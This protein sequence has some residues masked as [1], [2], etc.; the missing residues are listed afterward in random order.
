MKMYEDERG[1]LITI[2]ELWDEF[3]QL[4]AIDPVEYAYDFDE[5]VSN[6]TGKNGTLKEVE[7]QRFSYET[8]WTSV[9]R[10]LEQFLNAFGIRFEM[11]EISHM[12]RRFDMIGTEKQ[13]QQVVKF[14][15]EVAV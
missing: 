5:Y 7:V 13:R 8:L 10:Q 12:I 15:Q 3:E 1:G 2:G 4:Q 14:L 11:S 9:A 6:C